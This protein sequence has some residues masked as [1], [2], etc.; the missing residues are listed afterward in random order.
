MLHRF[1][2]T[3]L[4]VVCAL[5]LCAAVVGAD[6]GGSSAPAHFLTPETAGALRD[7]R[8]LAAFGEPHSAWT[9][10]PDTLD[11]PVAE[12]QRLLLEIRLLTELELYGRADSLLS[13]LTPISD[14]ETVFLHYLRRGKINQMAGRH[15]LALSCLEAT[16]SLYGGGFEPYRDFVRVSVLMD[17]KRS[18]RAV[19]AGESV[20]ETGVPAPLSPEFENLMILAYS[21]ADRPG[22]A[23]DLVEELR[24]HT[25]LS[26]HK[27]ALLATEYQLG[28]QAGE[29]D[30]ARKAAFKL[31]RV[32]RNNR[33][34]AEV[35]RDA[36]D[37]FGL[38]AMTSGEL[39]ALAGVFVEHG[40]YRQTRAVM[41]ALEKR[42]LSGAQREERQIVRARYRYS[43]GDYNGAAALAK[44][45][46]NVPAYRRESILILAR[47]HRRLGMKSRAADLYVYFSKNYPNDV[48]AA[49]ALFV[50]ARLYQRTGNRAAEGKILEKLRKSYPSSYFGRMAAYDSARRYERAGNHTRCVSILDSAV[51]RSRGTDETAMYYLARAY[52]SAG[53][54]DGYSRIVN[55]LRTLDPYSFYLAPSVSRFVWR[56]VTSSTGRIAMDGDDGLIRFLVDATRQKERAR[57]SVM[58]AVGGGDMPDEAVGECVERGAWFMEAGFRD[59]GE[60][61]LES[62]RSLCFDSP[63]ELLELGRVYDS[64]GMPWHSIRLYQRVKDSIHWKKR[65]QYAEQFRYLMYPVPYPVN[66][67]ENAARFELPPHL[68]YAM[69][70]EESRFDR[71]AVSRVGALGLMQLMPETGRY[72]ARELEVPEWVEDNLLDPATNLAFGIWYA[73]SLLAEPGGDYLRMLAAYNAG[74]SN[75]RRWFGSPDNGGGQTDASTIEVVDGIDFKETRLY[76]QRIVES[77]NIYQS[78]YFDDDFH[79]RPTE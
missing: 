76:V 51:R 28:L 5:G 39:L 20:L 36:L 17:L 41:N 48:K 9:Q 74:P 43:R 21:Q 19:E 40:M 53:D 31:A 59:W 12:R 27:A 75:A 55:N 1:F 3:A 18:A 73:S 60:R 42:R 66:V 38:S 35:S 47:S 79:G 58:D 15:Q 30:R 65:R 37:V 32:Y 14:P 70:R 29:P 34:A 64:Y 62:A 78:L 23:L 77:A 57:R 52:Q 56:P 63:A 13:L 45:R 22:E 71:R 61:E 7:A 10:V 4:S 44:P 6:H 46:F 69:I 2:T 54:E 8:V 72:V 16:D 11:D 49:E 67:L 26:T 50:A 68:V 24:R 25:R 33:N